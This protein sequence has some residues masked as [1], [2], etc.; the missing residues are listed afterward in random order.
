MQQEI[1]RL[2]QNNSKTL[3]ELSALLKKNESTISRNISQL[4][5]T[6]VL[7]RTGS[8]KTGEWKVIK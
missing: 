4:N 8:D 6:G 5:E 2:I 3:K 1:I 7:E